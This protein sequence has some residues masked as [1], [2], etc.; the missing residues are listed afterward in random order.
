MLLILLAAAALVGGEPTDAPAAKPSEG[1]PVAPVEVKGEKPKAK[2]VCIREKTTGSH[3]VETICYDA[4]QLEASREG[5]RN[6]SST[7]TG[8]SKS[9]IGAR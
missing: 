6:R 9:G 1:T 8:M 4:D 7:N 3:R 2:R 5:F